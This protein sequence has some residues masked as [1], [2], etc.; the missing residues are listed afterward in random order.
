VL[1]M[2]LIDAVE[3]CHRCSTAASIV[4][5]IVDAS[6]L[7]LVG[8][9]QHRGDSHSPSHQDQPGSSHIEAEVAAGPANIE[10]RTGANLLMNPLRTAAT[11]SLKGDSDLP[12]LLSL[13]AQ[14]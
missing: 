13:A 10:K 3:I 1:G 11:V 12:R 6:S 2:V 5:F 9:R 4:Q 14:G 7:R 8:H